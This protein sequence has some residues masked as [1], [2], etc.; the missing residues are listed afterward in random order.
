M[1]IGFLLIMQLQSL[2]AHRARHARSPFDVAVTALDDGDAER[3]AGCCVNGLPAA[4]RGAAG[5]HPMSR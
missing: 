5:P 4:G 2:F 1:F 3:H